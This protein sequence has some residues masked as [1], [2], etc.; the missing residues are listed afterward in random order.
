MRLLDLFCGAGGAAVGYHRAGFTEIVGVDHKPMPRYPFE[1]VQA[2]ALEY[3][4]EYG[5]EF[6]VI[7]ASPPCQRFTSMRVMA[8]AKPYPDLLTPCRE[9][10]TNIG[11]PFVIEN[12]ETAPMEYGQLGMFVPCGIMLCGSMFGL[13]NEEY[14]L[15][16]HRRF[17]C[18]MPLV[19]P[20][21]H[22]NGKEVIGFY[23]DHARKRTRIN[24]H[25]ARGNDI[26]ATAEKMALVRDLMGI[27]WMNWQEATQAIPPAYT[28]WIGKQLLAG[29]GREEEGQT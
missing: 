22:H 8:N 14:A 28:H 15:R 18:S 5:K 21:C 23:G 13:V 2:D 25:H 24:G 10:L 16:R 9:M 17:E 29:L 27:D 19:Q 26:T 11:L 12:V 7:H 4:R 1:F 20:K 3:L 6:D